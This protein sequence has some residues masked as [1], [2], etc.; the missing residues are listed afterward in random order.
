M[1]GCDVQF[2]D[3]LQVVMQSY[4]LTAALHTI[5]VLSCCQQG[6]QGV[7]VDCDV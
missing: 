1:H 7:L 5:V 3:V 4:L 2:A 6:H